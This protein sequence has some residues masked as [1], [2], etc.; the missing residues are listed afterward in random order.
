M[1]SL[2]TRL[3]KI[4]FVSNQYRQQLSLATLMIMITDTLGNFRRLWLLQTHSLPRGPGFGLKTSYS[5]HYCANLISG[6]TTSFEFTKNA[7]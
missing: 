7:F 5:H 6:I 3:T 4:R 2:D 1:V